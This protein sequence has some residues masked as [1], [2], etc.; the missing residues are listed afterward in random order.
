MVDQGRNQRSHTMVTVSYLKWL[1]V[2][3]KIHT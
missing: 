3:E 1:V 2:I